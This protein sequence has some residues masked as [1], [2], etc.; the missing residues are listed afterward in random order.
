MSAKYLKDFNISE[1]RKPRSLVYKQNLKFRHLSIFS[2][3][4]EQISMV[5]A[6]L[7]I[8]KYV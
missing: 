4:S 7:I 1:I 2:S 8:I 3:N 5:L 6:G